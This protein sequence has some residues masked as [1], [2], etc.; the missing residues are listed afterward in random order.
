MKLCNVDLLFHTGSGPPSILTQSFL[1]NI[2]AFTN[3]SYRVSPTAWNYDATGV[4]SAS[5]TDADGSW[6]R[7]WEPVG[8]TLPDRSLKMMN[9]DVVTSMTVKLVVFS[10]LKTASNSNTDP[11]TW[12]TSSWFPP[13]PQLSGG[14]GLYNVCNDSSWKSDQSSELWRYWEN[15]QTDRRM[16]RVS[17]EDG[18][19]RI[20]DI[21]KNSA[22]DGSFLNSELISVIYLLVRPSIFLSA[23]VPSCIH[24]S[25]HPLIFWPIHPSIDL[26]RSLYHSHHPPPFNHL[27]PCCHLS[28]LS[29]LISIF[30]CHTPHFSSFLFSSPFQISIFTSAR[31]SLNFH[32]SFILLFSTWT[33]CSRV[34]ESMWV[35][36]TKKMFKLVLSKYIH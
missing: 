20:R 36:G 6:P 15:R 32:F 25:T 10:E 34:L 18:G 2:P 1:L 31:Q 27:F 35:I 26:S 33:L 11:Q 3:K 16:S 5:Q 19:R 17:D 7:E 22:V 14:V 23:R 4:P 21:F 8:E 13:E 30:F 29:S 9:V 28:I 12:I 24:S